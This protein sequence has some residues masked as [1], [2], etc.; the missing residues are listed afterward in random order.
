MEDVIS[1]YMGLTWE[2]FLRIL[3]QALGHHRYQ[4]RA[5]G[6]IRVD[7]AGGQ[8]RIVLHPTAQRR[9]GALVLPT[10][11]VDFLF[12]NLAHGYRARFLERL[13]RHF[14]RGGG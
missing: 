11:R 13:Q 6:N 14:Q 5:G 3:P 4:V 1:R 7:Y 8:V 9:L 2:D 10:T 12:R